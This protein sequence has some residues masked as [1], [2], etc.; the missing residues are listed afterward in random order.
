[1]SVLFLLC[2]YIVI[3]SVFSKVELQIPRTHHLLRN[4]L[5]QN[6]RDQTTLQTPPDLSKY[7]GIAKNFGVYAAANKRLSLIRKKR[8]VINWCRG[9]GFRV[10]SSAQRPPVALASYPGSGNTW[11]RYLLQ[12]ATG[13]ATG[14]IYNDHDLLKNGFP[15]EAVRDGRVLVVKTHVP[16]KANFSKA[17]LLLRDPFEA[18]LAEYNRR[19]G[20]HI[21]H[22]SP[23]AFKSKNWRNLVFGEIKVWEKVNFYWLNTFK[24]DPQNL[25]V[26]KY[27]DLVDSTG[28]ELKKIL[29]FLH[30][31]VPD[32]I[33]K[34]VMERRE[35]S[36]H[37]SKQRH[38]NQ[39]SA[40]DESMRKYVNPIKE[41]VYKK[42]NF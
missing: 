1:M 4:R 14:S 33:M 20:G 41:R 2:I 35:G 15:G 38:F 26:V 29:D 17:I 40:F 27:R 22:A 42:F 25:I 6:T 12:Q 28:K 5:S 13:I 10:A 11:L 24:D 19:S 37:R 36:H 23:N 21:G 31:D 18:M 16:S 7:H 32:K 30:V 34:C 3:L 9:L 39:S 8:P